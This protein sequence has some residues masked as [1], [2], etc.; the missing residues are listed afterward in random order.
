MVSMLSRM[1]RCGLS[2]NTPSGPHAAVPAAIAH[3]AVTA[4]RERALRRITGT[5]KTPRST[6]IPSWYRPDGARP[7]A[8]DPIGP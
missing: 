4:A 3:R 8:S 7:I 2:E 5:G 6:P 1:I